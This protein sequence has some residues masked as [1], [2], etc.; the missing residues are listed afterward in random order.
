VAVA[1][2][3][4]ALV[5]AVGIVLAVRGG[6]EPDATAATSTSP[7]VTEL[8]LEPAGS[9]GDDPFTASVAIYERPLAAEASFASSPQVSGTEPGLY[10]G[11]QD[12]AVCDPAALVAF[13]DANREKA[14]AWAAVLDMAPGAIG[15]YV[16]TLTPVALR[17]DTRV[18][19]H[20][21][22]DGVATPRQSVLQAGT[23][24]MV[25]TYGVPRVRCSCGNPLTEPAPLESIP[26]AVADGAARVV[27][28]PWAGWNPEV[29]V[30]VNGTVSVNQFVVWDLIN[31]G[32]YTVLIGGTPATTT[33]TAAPTTTTTRP[34]T[35]TTAAPLVDPRTDDDCRN[36]PPSEDGEYGSG[37]VG[38]DPST[39]EYVCYLGAEQVPCPG[40]P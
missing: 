2:V 33:T 24:V 23:A 6:D 25:D 10:G 19:N 40:R 15:D 7:P 34:S 9:S 5:A 21:F 20:G 27:G 30:I 18:T 4:L 39:G 22:A 13:L 32:T 36:D 26:A 17:A 38:C 11:T 1:I 3:F 16:A 12:Q 35:T 37:D 8:V 14:A 29:V 28:Q 31:G